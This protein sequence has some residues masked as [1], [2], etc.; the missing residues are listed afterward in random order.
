MKYFKMVPNPKWRCNYCGDVSRHQFIHESP[1]GET[2]LAVIETCDACY[3]LEV[4]SGL[5]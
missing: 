2:K 4:F 5:E 1:D 3:R